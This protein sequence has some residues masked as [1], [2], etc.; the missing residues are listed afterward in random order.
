MRILPVITIL[1]LLLCSLY[2]QGA[3]TRAKTQSERKKPHVNVGTI[4]QSG[5]GK[6]TLTAAIT[7]VLAERQLAKLVPLEAIDK[8]PEERERGITI[9]IARVEY[10]TEK[11]HYLHVDCPGHADYIKSMIT[12]A[13]HAV[14]QWV[15][16]AVL[17]SHDGCDGDGGLAGGDGDGDAGG[18]HADG[19]GVIDA[20]RDG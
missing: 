5:H 14:L 17:L 19:G 8:A 1:A 16:A 15:S 18:Q 3:E 11:R 4:G 12:G 20:D 6:T 13:A 2:T 9:H 10:E 7:R